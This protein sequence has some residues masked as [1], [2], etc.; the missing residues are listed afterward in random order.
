M[1]SQGTLEI[2]G[3]IHIH[4]PYI[5]TYISLSKYICIVL[6]GKNLKNK[7]LFGKMDPYVVIRV[8]TESKRTSV[9]KNGGCNPVFNDTFTFNVIPGINQ[10]E[11]E[12]YD[13]DFLS[14]DFIGSGRLPLDEVFRLGSSNSR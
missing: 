7:D 8:G 4:I 12:T 13:K 3:N 9:V 1:T 14:D 10:L 5:Y 6:E 11:L 2:K